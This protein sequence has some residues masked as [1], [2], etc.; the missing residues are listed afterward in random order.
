MNVAIDVTAMI[1]DRGVSRYTSNLVSALASQPNIKLSLYG[2]S[3]RQ[4][5][6]LESLCYH[7]LTKTN[8][9]GNHEVIIQ[10]IPPT[11]QEIIWKLGF[12]S[13]RSQLSNPQV[14][15]SWDWL[16]PP[17]KDLPLVSTIHD[18][19]ILKF[20]QTAHQKILE[21]HQR[22]WRILREREAEIIAVSQATK[23]DIIDL[24]GIPSNKITVIPEAL[25]IEIADVSEKMTEDVYLATKQQLMLDQPYILFVGTREPRKNL[26]NLIEAWKPLSKDYQLIIAGAEGWDKI[27]YQNSNLRFLGKVSNQ[28]LA[29]LYG[30]ASMF[31]YPSL[32]EGFGLPI[33]ES[34]YYGTPVLTS[35]VPAL[36]EV[37]GN[38]AELVDPESVKDIRDGMTK[39]LNETKEEQQ[40]RLQRMI[41]RLQMFNWDSVAK[42]TIQV[43]QK[44][45]QGKE[46]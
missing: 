1:Y 40:K 26:S 23:K 15:H 3:F 12:N 5:A 21:M 14:F 13:I 28:Q 34:F 9:P 6:E 32:Y 44:A 18:L 24:L 10:S 8:R 16:Q 31:A 19:A 25:P 33:L 17:D 41:I 45:L 4:K 22:S 43:Y 46:K 2:S 11:L 30:E 35:N 42:K 7:I 29:V 37:A 39:L 20:P 36:I 38:A 27:N